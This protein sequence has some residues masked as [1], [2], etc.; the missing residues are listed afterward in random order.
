M[1]R[2]PEVGRGL[3]QLDGKRARRGSG[4]S[5]SSERTFGHPETGRQ[6]NKSANA[7]ADSQHDR[8]RQ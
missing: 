5:E 1:T 2:H 4:I 3:S 7:H 6:G 8:A